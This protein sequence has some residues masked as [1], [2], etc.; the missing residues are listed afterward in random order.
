MATLTGR[1]PDEHYQ[2]LEA[3]AQLT[4]VKLAE[5]IRGMVEDFLRSRD[6][7][8]IEQRFDEL[9]TQRHAML[10]AAKEL[11]TSIKTTSTD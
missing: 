9:H 6:W 3:Y 7:T 1:I 4:G 5:V 2:A 8:E 10:A 11:A